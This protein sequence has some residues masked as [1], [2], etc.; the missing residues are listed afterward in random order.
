MNIQLY[1]YD[2]SRGVARNLS[3]ALLGIQ[4]DAVY[5]TSIVFEGVE[6]VYDGGVKTVRPGETH[7]GRPL[8][9]LELG[10]TDLPM[11]VILEYLESLKSIYTL[12]VHVL[13]HLNSSR[14]LTLSSGLRPLETQLQ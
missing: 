14:Q 2:L 13:A 3:A 12:E 6:Y 1:V 9:I 8:Q 10:K 11:D 4:I 7:L 5:H